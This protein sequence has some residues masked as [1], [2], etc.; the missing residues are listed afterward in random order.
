MELRE[1]TVA[2]RCSVLKLKR[3][4]FHK[5]YP[6]LKGRYKMSSFHFCKRC[7]HSTTDVDTIQKYRDSERARDQDWWNSSQYVTF[8]SSGRDVYSRFVP[9]FSRFVLIFIRVFNNLI[10]VLVFILPRGLNF[11]ECYTWN[12]PLLLLSCII[13][14]L[15][16]VFESTGIRIDGVRLDLRVELQ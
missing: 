2:T 5:L 8:K 3:R 9:S 12:V 11:E 14:T 15:L 1:S 16:V 10:S 13:L 4:L 6:N 7:L